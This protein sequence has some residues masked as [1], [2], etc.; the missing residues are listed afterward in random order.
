[1]TLPW[2]E[3]LGLAGLLLVLLAFLFLQLRWFVGHNLVYQVM[4]AAGAACA[5][6]SL[7]V[8][9]FNLIGFLF[10]VA[11]LA[12]SLFGAVMAMRRWRAGPLT[13]EDKARSYKDY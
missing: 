5:L 6:I 9:R 13:A 11:W 7:L 12:I 8:G 4:N 3:W 10:M 1:M 2:Y